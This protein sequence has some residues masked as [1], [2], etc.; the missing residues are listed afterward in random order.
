[1]QRSRSKRKTLIMWQ[2]EINW[3]RKVVEECEIETTE[4]EVVRDCIRYM[5]TIKEGDPHLI[6][7]LDYYKGKLPC[8]NT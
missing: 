8:T 3:V 7:V 5:M 4:S 1:M 2:T 6:S